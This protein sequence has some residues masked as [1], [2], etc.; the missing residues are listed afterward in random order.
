[1]NKHHTLR[2][3][4]KFTNVR[5]LVEWA[6]D[7]YGDKTAYS[8]RIPASAEESTKVSFINLRDDVRALASEMAAMGCAG[9]QCA[10]I[11]KFSYQWAVTYFAALSIGAI[12]VPLDRDWLADDL[13]DTV[14]KANADFLSETRILRKSSTLSQKA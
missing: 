8:F 10:L 2:K 13:A 7:T 5:Q 3:K 11:G 6:A 9:R 4:Q 1:M 14:K 12:L